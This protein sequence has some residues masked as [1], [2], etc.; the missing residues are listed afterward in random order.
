MRHRT[1]TS[2]WVVWRVKPSTMNDFMRLE[3]HKNGGI[4]YILFN[5]SLTVY[6]GFAEILGS[7]G[8]F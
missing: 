4:L 3:I 2:F 5:A 1:F 8:D 6:L 7:M